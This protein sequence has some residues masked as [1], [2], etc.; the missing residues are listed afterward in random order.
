[1]G[2]RRIVIYS[3]KK[4]PS[5]CAFFSFKYVNNQVI[6]ILDRFAQ[7]ILLIIIK[8]LYRDY[9]LLSNIFADLIPH[10]ISLLYLVYSMS[11]NQGFIIK[12]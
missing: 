10:L 4:V 8:V 11:Y 7:N 1:M 2:K 6:G 5:P 9:F 3:L 12:D